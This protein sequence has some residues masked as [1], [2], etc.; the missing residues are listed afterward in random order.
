MV[1][2]QY[3]IFFYIL[4]LEKKRIG[5]KNNILILL[6]NGIQVQKRWFCSSIV[7][8]LHQTKYKGSREEYVVCP[9]SPMGQN[10]TKKS[11]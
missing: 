10:K 9:F 5:V 3:M 4:Q 11:P 2:V 8:V 7:L 6:K 1:Q